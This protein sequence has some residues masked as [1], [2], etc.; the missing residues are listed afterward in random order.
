MDVLQ[1]LND[2]AASGALQARDVRR[3]EQDAT[4][5]RL[6]DAGERLA[7]RGLAA[8][9]LADDAERFARPHIERDVVERLDRACAQP[10]HVVHR[11]MPLELGYLQQ[12]R[13]RTHERASCRSGCG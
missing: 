1:A 4:R 6:V 7:E 12:G 11:E 9:E 3:L 10:E 5:A 8:T 2:R 13:L